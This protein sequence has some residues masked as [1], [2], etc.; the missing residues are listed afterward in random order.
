MA[1]VKGWQEL[2]QRR[3]MIRLCD[4]RLR[5][6]HGG[7]SRE[8]IFK[9]WAALKADIERSGRCLGT[10]DISGLSNS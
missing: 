2:L 5:C 3:R 1:N 9:E 4:E 8:E 6:S 7:R 10:R